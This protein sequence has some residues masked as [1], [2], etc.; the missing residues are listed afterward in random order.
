MSK[1]ISRHSWLVEPAIMEACISYC[2]VKQSTNGEKNID[3]AAYDPSINDM[4]TCVCKQRHLCNLTVPNFSSSISLLHL[5]RE[6]FACVQQ[7]FL[8][9][10]EPHSAS[11]IKHS[12]TLFV[13][14]RSL[15]PA[16]W[17]AWAQWWTWCAI[18]S[19][20]FIGAYIIHHGT[21]TLF[22]ENGLK[23]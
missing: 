21:A 10:L 18:V 14:P 2:S 22:E 17:L 5:W 19:K 4:L 16:S 3:L 11:L 20:G 1:D 8:A 15:L 6:S 12:F 9:S 13:S 7:S 23:L